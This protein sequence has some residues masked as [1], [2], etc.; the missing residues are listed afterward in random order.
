MFR[1]F[2]RIGLAALALFFATGVTAQNLSIATGGTGG[3]YYPLGGGMASVLSKHV[4]G[5]QAT[6]EVTGGSVAG[7]HHRRALS[8]PDAPG[9]RGRTQYRQAVRPEGQACVDRVARQRYRSDGV[10]HTRGGRPRQGQG[11]QAR[12]AVGSTRSSGSA[13][14][15]RQR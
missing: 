9:D 6:A 5:L 2:I 10:P 3:V 15:R 14:C 1:Q 13:A 4:P 12:T 8:E 11:R 7:P